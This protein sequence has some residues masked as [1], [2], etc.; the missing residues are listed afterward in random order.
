MA[1][2]IKRVLQFTPQRSWHIRC[3]RAPTMME[4]FHAKPLA[5][6]L[7][8]A[9]LWIARPSK[10]DEDDYTPSPRT[11]VSQ[12]PRSAPVPVAVSTQVETRRN[13]YGWQTL[14]TD[15]AAFSL[16]VLGGSLI[17]NDNTESGV[18]VTD[19]FVILSA[20]SYVFGAPIVHAAHQN[21][22]TAAASL[23]L[24]V[25][26]PLT[27]ILIGSAADR[28]GANNDSELCGAVGPGFGAL[29]GI[30]A[31]IAIDAA[32]LAYEQAPLVSAATT[33]QPLAAVSAPFVVADAHRTMLGVMGTF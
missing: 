2:G 16:L 28:C 12:T 4:R 33:L 19:S 13:W 24:R 5:L 30:S 32:A 15:G 11:S 26:L 20:A 7:A 6:A 3:F 31:A 23:G 10:A 25:G 21:W 1:I 29:L 22:G 8:L 18:V 27:G 9:T 17:S 14:S